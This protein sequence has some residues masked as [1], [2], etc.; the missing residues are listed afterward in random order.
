M[1]LSLV[2]RF[3]FQYKV[4]VIEGIVSPEGSARFSS[5]APENLESILDDKYHV[6]IQMDQDP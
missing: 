5:S 2:L 6:Y 1:R 3:A 4:I